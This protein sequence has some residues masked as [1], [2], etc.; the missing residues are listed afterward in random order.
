MGSDQTQAHLASHYEFASG[1]ESPSLT[2]IPSD[3]CSCLKTM[4]IVLENAGDCTDSTPLDGLMSIAGHSIFQCNEI[5]SCINCSARFPTLLANIMQQLATV[6]N[7]IS[8]LFLQQNQLLP[9]TGDGILAFNFSVGKYQVE[10]EHMK[11][12]LLHHLIMLQLHEFYDLLNKLKLHSGLKQNS[13][14]MVSTV[15]E[16]I[17][18]ITRSIRNF[19]DDLNGN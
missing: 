1:Q 14:G 10:N 17:K 4:V 19:L 9:N 13:L 15:E 3:D 11:R 8:K 12:Q 6:F 2:S 5:I 7:R 18:I 16:E